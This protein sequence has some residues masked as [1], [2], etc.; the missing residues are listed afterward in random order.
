MLF[1]SQ[2]YK[3]P[4]TEAKKRMEQLIADFGLNQYKKY[5]VSSY[6]GGV[7]RRLDI[8]L[9]MMS[10]PK[11]L[12]LDEPTVGMDLQSRIAMWN[13][14]KK[15]RDDFGTTIFL[16]THYLEEADHLSNTICIMKDGKDV[17]QGSPLKLRSF[18][19]QNTLQLQFRSHR[20]AKTYLSSLQERFPQ[21]AICT[22]NTAVTMITDESRVDMEQVIRFLL[23]Q[24]IP[25]YGIEIAQPTLEDVFLWMNR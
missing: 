6:S 2:L 22:K 12:F 25:F 15:I 4:E 9:T 21:K 11:L 16:T 24:H 3:I 20:E 17:I 13:M 18:L 8:A 1:Q 7:K 23:E 10:N 19:R 5:P 14:L